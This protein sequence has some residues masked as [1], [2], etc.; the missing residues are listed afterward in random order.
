MK[1]PRMQVLILLGCSI[2]PSVALV[3]LLC[4]S[5]MDAMS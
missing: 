5:G 4:D 1:S 3:V 2:T